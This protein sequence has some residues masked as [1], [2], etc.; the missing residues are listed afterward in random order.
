[1]LLKLPIHN[2]FII[3]NIKHSHKN[4]Y[5]C[6]VQTRT[7]FNET[8]YF[9]RRKYEDNKNQKEEYIVSVEFMNL[10]RI[11]DDEINRRSLIK[12]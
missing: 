2:A 8:T 10:N 1:M 4:K 7:E 3:F 9:D 5:R 11:I 12:L 6:F